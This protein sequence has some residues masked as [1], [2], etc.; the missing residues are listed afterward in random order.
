MTGRTVY[1]NHT[2]GQRVRTEHTS[3]L[4]RHLMGRML[5]LVEDG[6]RI[7][8]A[9]D[10]FIP[11]MGPVCVDFTTVENSEMVLCLAREYNVF[12]RQAHQGPVVFSIGAG[13]TF[14]DIDYAQGAVYEILCRNQ[15][16]PLGKAK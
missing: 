12:T 9:Q 15:K 3:R 8:G 4:T 13:T 1:L 16:L 7:L 5:E 11:Q 14:E 10:P 2:E 6:A